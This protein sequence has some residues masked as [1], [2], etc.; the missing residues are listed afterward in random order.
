V[1]PMNETA[2]DR[3]LRRPTE[4]ATFKACLGAFERW[5]SGEVWCD[6]S[7]CRSGYRK[8]KMQIAWEAWIAVLGMHLGDGCN[9]LIAFVS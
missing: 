2:T 4:S 5:A 7:P 9:G 1:Y 6:V 8:E 3:R